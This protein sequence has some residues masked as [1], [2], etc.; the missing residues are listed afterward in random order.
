MLPLS[1]L[2][3]LDRYSSSSGRLLEGPLLQSYHGSPRHSYGRYGGSQPWPRRTSARG[4][5][6]K[7]ALLTALA[8]ACW[9]GFGHVKGR[10]AAGTSGGSSGSDAPYLAADDP[11]GLSTDASKGW[12]KLHT[13]VSDLGWKLLERLG[14]REWLLRDADAAG[15]THA[16][17]KK[18]RAGR[19][20]CVRGVSTRHG[21]RRG[22]LRMPAHTNTRCVP[23]RAVLRC[24]HL[25]GG[26]VR[27][28]RR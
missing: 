11:A 2:R 14:K 1:R 25:T 17:G 8:V 22:R 15:A 23:T 28:T 6:L 24:M 9:Q 5:L 12:S 18:A 19:C 21:S 26:W 3:S 20:V 13:T 16:A 27:S 7:V 4:V 10:L